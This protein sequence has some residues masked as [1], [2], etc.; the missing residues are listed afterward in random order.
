LIEWWRKHDNTVRPHSALG[1]PP[2][3]PAAG[4]SLCS[5]RCRSLR[6]YSEPA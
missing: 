1:Y 3:A 2:P 5:P 6:W 4:R